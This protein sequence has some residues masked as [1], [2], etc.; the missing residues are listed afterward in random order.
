MKLK[1]IVIVLST[2][3]II[4]ITAGAWSISELTYWQ[5]LSYHLKRELIMFMFFVPLAWIVGVLKIVYLFL[6]LKPNR[7]GRS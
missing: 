1:A 3:T 2:W 4:W 7:G 6:F 5:E